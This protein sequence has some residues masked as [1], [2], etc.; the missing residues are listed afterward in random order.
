MSLSI[1]TVNDGTISHLR[2]TRARNRYEYG[3]AYAPFVTS[4]SLLRTVYSRTNFAVAKTT[5]PYL[6]TFIRPFYT[7][8]IGAFLSMRI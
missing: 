6:Y 8:S 3:Y 2:D 7:H 4:S 5:H 1:Q